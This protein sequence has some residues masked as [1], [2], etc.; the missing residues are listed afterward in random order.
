MQ[1]RHLVPLSPAQFNAF[2]CPE[3]G[4]EH[5][6]ALGTVWPG[7][8]VMG[9][10]RCPSCHLEFLRDMPIGFAV[11]HPMAIAMD[12]GKLYNP[13]H[14]ENWIHGPLMKAFGNPKEQSVHIERVV[15]RECR[16]VVVLNT[17][18]FLYGHVLLK[19]FNAHH[20]LRLAPDLGL[21]VLVPRMFAWLVPKGVAE[22]WIVDLGLGALQGWYSALDA[23]MQ[24]R[25]VK[26]DEVFLARGYSH[27]GLVGARMEDYT[28]VR[29]FDLDRFSSLPPHITFV[30]RRDRLWYRNQLSKFLHRVL[31]KVGLGSISAQLFI[32]DQDRLV[33][34]CIK[35]LRRKVPGITFTLVGLGRPRRHP[36]YIEDLRTQQ[37]DVEKERAWCE[38]YA[39][40]HAVAGVHGS[41]M[42]LPSALAAGCVEILPHDRHGNLAQDIAVRHADRLQL[43][44]YRFVDEFASPAIVARHLRSMLRD[45][46]RYRNNMQVN[47]P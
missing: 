29:S 41:N 12:S 24:D 17:L 26:Y 31:K 2:P 5:P 35:R 28:G 34:A 45:F 42:L 1:D 40:S 13:T 22:A 4:K 11:E 36:S 19:L 15:N 23:F 9:K 14:G 3:C 39:R 27:P 21:V 10:Y 44:L 37:M 18:D 32:G 47:I 46:D 6:A 30:L 8:H 33:A 43:F 25:L 20:Y 38:A 7:I 16:R